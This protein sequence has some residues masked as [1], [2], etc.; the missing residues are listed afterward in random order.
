M[1]VNHRLESRVRENRTH[2]S[3]GGEAAQPAFPTPIHRN[4][5]QDAH[6]TTTSG[7][8]TGRYKR[9]EV[10]GIVA[11]NC[12]GRAVWTAGG[13]VGRGYTA[14]PDVWQR[15]PGK[16]RLQFGAAYLPIRKWAPRR[17][18]TD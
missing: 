1:Q 5:E 4:H 15:I 12:I 8:G 17:G 11:P 16:R 13:C 9:D 18:A 14:S 7:A 10:R 3:E 6:A 2:G